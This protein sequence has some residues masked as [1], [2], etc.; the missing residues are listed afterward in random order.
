MKIVK[1]SLILIALI[2]LVPIIGYWV[3]GRFFYDYELNQIKSELNKIENVSVI[4]IWGYEDFTLENI[5]ARIK[6]K[7]K[8]EIELHALSSDADDYRDRVILHEIDGYSFRTFSCFDYEDM[9]YHKGLGFSIDISEN[10]EIGKQ[11]G[12]EFKNLK[13]IIENY[14]NI[15]NTV[16]SLKK[17]PESNY[18]KNEKEEIYILVYRD[19]NDMK[20][21]FKENGVDNLADFQLTFNFENPECK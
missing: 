19:E 7:G 14:D 11:I 9:G 20:S 1:W 4:D 17:I 10:S 8:G 13:T 21:L 12:I 3:Y 18:Y 16:E 2:F 5:S 15:L 6:V